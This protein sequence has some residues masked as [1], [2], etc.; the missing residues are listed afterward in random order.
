MPGPTE[1]LDRWIRL[2]C[3]GGHRVSGSPECR[4]AA[5]E[6]RKGMEAAGLAAEAEEFHFRPSHPHGLVLHFSALVLSALLSLA[7]HSTS[8][9]VLAAVAYAS[10]VGS[11]TG[12]F[13]LLNLVLRPCRG[14]NVVGRWNPGGARRLVLF[15]HYDGTRQARV[16]EPVRAEKFARAMKDLPFFLRAPFFLLN[17]GILAV[18]LAAL[19]GLAGLRSAVALPALYGA[20]SLGLGVFIMQDWM[21]G[22]PIPAAN[23]NASAVAAMM[24]FG[25]DLR[26]RCPENLEV[27][28]V[29]TDAEELGLKGAAAFC[30]RHAKGLGDKPTFFVN[31]ES[32]GS[33]RLCYLAREAGYI[34]PG[35]IWYSPLAREM[36]EA[37]ARRLGK[38]SIPVE[39]A[40]AG[41]DGQVLRRS[42]L[43]G[44]SLL[45]L[46]E[47]G[48]VEN[49]HWPT[50][51]PENVDRSVAAEAV[52]WTWAI[53]EAWG[54]RRD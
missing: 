31:L 23:D 25:A 27:W 3:R 32:L 15:A 34:I 50:D 33:G 47:I 5:A 13:D 8:A 16:F 6:I 53:A 45:G 10:A 38:P 14:V 9:L 4:A 26:K 30:K 35:S 11:E 28:L 7:G 36:V 49:Y 12:R 48:Y 44:V 39:D 41:T 17:L 1:T 24:A 2:L 21:R 42:G 19:S 18:F 40:P 22:R 52:E 37:A 20:A 51:T 43:Q 46:L 54:E 29:A